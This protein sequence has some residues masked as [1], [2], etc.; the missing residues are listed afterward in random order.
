MWWQLEWVRITSRRWLPLGDPCCL[1][2]HVDL[3]VFWQR[4][5]ESWLEKKIVRNVCRFGTAMILRRVKGFVV[6]WLRSTK[7]NR[8]MFGW[9]WNVV[10]FLGCK[11]WIRETTDKERNWLRNVQ[12]AYDNTWGGCWYT[13]TVCSRAY[14]SRGSGQKHVMLGGCPWFNG[15]FKS[16]NPNFVL[17]RVVV[18]TLE[19]PSQEPI[20][21]KVGNWQPHTSCWRNECIYRVFAKKSMFFVRAP[22][23]GWVL[24]TRMSL[25]KE[26][27]RQ[28]W[29]DW[30]FRTWRV[31]FWVKRVFHGNFR[32]TVRVVRVNW[33]VTPKAIWSVTTARKIGRNRTP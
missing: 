29:T 25:R 21:E 28:L 6:S 14:R 12:T 31:N 26:C 2:L 16:I 18:W 3:T 8:C 23:L 20:W 30:T 13:H 5:W 11:T 9:A 19:I 1:R 15:C 10:P 7:I 24:T 32:A 4:T 22:L 27:V 17:S 33:F